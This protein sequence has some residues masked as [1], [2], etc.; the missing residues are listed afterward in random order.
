MKNIYQ[1]SLRF[2]L[3]IFILTIGISIA[4]KS[5]LGSPPV[6]S[7]PY[8][9]TVITGLEMGL[10]TILFQSF[11][12]I[13]QLIVLRKDFKWK[14]L[15]QVFAGIVFGWM[16]TLSNSLIAFLPN[17][18]NYILRILMVLV[19]CF[20]IA[21]GIALYVPANIMPLPSEGIVKAMSDKTGK[22]FSTMKI[23]FDC[24]MVTI[25]LT[26]CLI[27]TKTLGSVG[28]GTII[29]AVMVGLMNR[30]I[31]KIISNISKSKKSKDA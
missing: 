2:I 11:L 8:T 9:L 6:S 28:V 13:L 26:L 22:A 21:L 5:N 24:T 30:Q 7:F 27:F 25:S 23:V 12:V 19:G 29:L 17:T 14:N 4:I 15:L 18:D 10:G 20:F 1:R 3:G 16:T 31:T